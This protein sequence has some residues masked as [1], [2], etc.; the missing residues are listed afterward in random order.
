MSIA[1]TYTFTPSNA[2]NPPVTV[3]GKASESEVKAAVAAVLQARLD[4]QVAN[5][6]AVTAALDS[7]NA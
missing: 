5:V 3:T 6:A 7:V 1:A 2:S 4:A